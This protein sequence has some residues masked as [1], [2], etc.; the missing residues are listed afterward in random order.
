MI[1]VCK[2]LS[3]FGKLILILDNLKILDNNKILLFENFL[4]SKNIEKEISE[5]LKMVVILRSHFCRISPKHN[6]LCNL[7]S[8]SDYI[9]VLAC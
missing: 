6:Q 9:T 2:L 7:R 1:Y 4:S 3:A 5:L 8:V